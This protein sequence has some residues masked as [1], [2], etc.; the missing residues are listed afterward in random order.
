MVLPTLYAQEA[1]QPTIMVMPDKS[2]CARN[3]YV[4]EGATDQPDYRKALADKNFSGVLT[5]MGDIMAARD[6]PLTD[7]EASLDNLENERAMDMTHMS[8]GDGMVQESE[9]D[10]IVRVANADILVYLDCESK[11]YGP[12]TIIEFR[13]KAVDAASLKQIAGEVGNSP[14]SGLPLPTILNQCAIEFMDHFCNQITRHLEDI[15]NRGREGSISIAIADDC[16]IHSFEQ[17]IEFQGEYGELADLIDYW[18]DNNTV[19]GV[20]TQNTKTRNKLN[21]TQVRFPLIGAASSGFGSKKPKALQMN[22]FVKPLGKLLQSYGI[23]MSTTP[24]GQGRVHI[25]LGGNSY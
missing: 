16:P 7:L 11:P 20:Y 24:I 19:N 1:K 9:F 10:M 25:V 3:G 15:Y 4:L 17:E 22:D 2:W 5:K 14:S 12:R 8:K 13:I 21:Y 18:L 23:S 6:Y